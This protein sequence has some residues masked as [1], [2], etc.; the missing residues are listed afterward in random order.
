MSELYVVFLRRN[1]NLF[2]LLYGHNE[3]YAG[4][5]LYILMFC[6]VQL[7]RPLGLPARALYPFT[8]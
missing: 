2:W 7:N 1:Q 5:E 3:G 8:L 4:W 6:P